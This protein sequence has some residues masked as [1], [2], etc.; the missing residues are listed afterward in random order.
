YE[1][2]QTLDADYAWGWIELRRLYQEAGRLPEARRAAEQALANAQN[3]RDRAAAG[4]KLGDVLVAAGDLAGARARFE[5]SLQIRER[6]ASANPSSADAQRD[7][8]I[9][10][11]R[12]HV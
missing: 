7:L 1:T 9:E 2:A 8:S 11:G 3:D 6:L 10:I 12:A 5:Q 4:T